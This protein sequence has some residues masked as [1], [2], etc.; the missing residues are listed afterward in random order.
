M[1]PKFIIIDWASNV[2]FEER[3]QTFRLIMG[4]AA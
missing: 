1:T 2:L 3:R 4:G